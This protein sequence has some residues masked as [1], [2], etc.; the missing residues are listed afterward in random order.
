MEFT[1]AFV[2]KEYH[3]VL[4]GMAGQRSS[5]S[6]TPARVHTTRHGTKV[7]QNTKRVLSYTGKHY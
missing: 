2:E 1:A 3:V 6:P 5:Q 7:P 4:L